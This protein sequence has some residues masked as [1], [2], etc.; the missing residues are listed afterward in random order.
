VG[1]VVVCA[2]VCLHAALARRLAPLCTHAQ[3]S[4]PPDAASA[5][6]VACLGRLLGQ[7][8]AVV[9]YATVFGFVGV[10]CVAVAVFV[11]VLLI[12]VVADGIIDGARGA[13]KT[14]D[15][16]RTTPSTMTTTADAKSRCVGTKW[17][18]TS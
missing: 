4:T 8:A 14:I 2:A 10:L 12:E 11:T 6:C 7:I 13:L 18:C 5:R 15:D 1:L 16:L 3:P 9:V 17:G